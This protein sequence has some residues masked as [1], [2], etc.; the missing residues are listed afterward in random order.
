MNRIKKGPQ[1]KQPLQKQK[2]LGE[3][4]SKH[5]GLA[6]MTASCLTIAVAI[7]IAFGFGAGAGATNPLLHESAVK[8]A[9]DRMEAQLHGY[10]A[11][12]TQTVSATAKQSKVPTFS[13]PKGIAEGNKVIAQASVSSGGGAVYDA[14]KRIVKIVE[15]RAGS[16]TSTKQFVWAGDQL[17]EERDATGAVTRR[18]FNLGEQIGGTNYYYTR[19]HNNSVREM[20]NGA[21][22]VQSQYGYGP[23]GEVSKLAGTGPDS[24]MQYAGMYMHQ[25][26]GLNLAVNRAYSPSQGRWISRDP[27][28]D[29]TFGMTPSSPE[30]VDPGAMQMSSG[31][32]QAQ[33]MASNPNMMT[34][35][36]VSSNPM[37]QAQVAQAMMGSHGP[38][39]SPSMN[40][41]A[42]VNNNPISLRDPTGL[43][44]TISC[45]PHPCEPGDRV[46]S[47][48]NYCWNQPAA[49]MNVPG[50]LMQCFRT[51]INKFSPPGG[52][53]PPPID[54]PG[55]VSPLQP[56][57]PG[58]PHR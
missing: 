35:Q 11:P 52:Q 17:C 48:L 55:K 46:C 33:A 54:T 25:P 50:F 56:F 24:D 49:A 21:G 36:M 28:D 16:V 19:D 20:T 37:V 10:S 4:L 32:G 12:T 8:A 30:P 26:S 45:A 29:P 3:K 57:D 27:I 41:Y 5:R 1:R 44:P 58:M 43:A 18:F 23:W 34:I 53:W 51:C 15:T 40:Q 42:Y 7:A 47:C 2:L 31:F 6:L 39:D 9:S 13:A 14:E 38:A 22:T